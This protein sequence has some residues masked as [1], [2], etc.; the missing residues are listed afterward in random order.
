MCLL[1]ET[2]AL[3]AQGEKRALVGN[4]TMPWPWGAV[5]RSLP[6]GTPR[7]ATAACNQTRPAVRGPISGGSLPSLHPGYRRINFSVELTAF[8]MIW[9]LVV[10]AGGVGCTRSTQRAARFALGV[11]QVTSQ[12]M[13]D[14]PPRGLIMRPDTVRGYRPD[15]VATKGR[16]RKIIEVETPDSVDS[17]RD[18]GQ[19]AAFRQAAKQSKNTSF[20]A[21]AINCCYPALISF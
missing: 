20:G 12:T 9:S 16:E 1:T 7:A 13:Q 17:A 5:P 10:E 18:R 3:S 4:L 21:S 11:P 15:V 2:R 8:I 6:A 14:R 19:Q